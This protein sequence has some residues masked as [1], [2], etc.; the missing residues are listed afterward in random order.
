MARVSCPEFRFQFSKSFHID[1]TEISMAAKMKRQRAHVPS[2]Q[3]FYSAIFV[4]ASFRFRCALVVV[5]AA[6]RGFVILVL[7]AF[8]GGFYNCTATIGKAKRPTCRWPG[9]NDLPAWCTFLSKI[10]CICHIHHENLVTGIWSFPI[11]RGI[12]PCDT[13]LR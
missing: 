7:S 5:F 8:V 4:I 6:V 3:I 13:Y 1:C 2:H 9:M 10:A 12:I 11:W